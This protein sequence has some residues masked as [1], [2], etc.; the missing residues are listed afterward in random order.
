MPCI[1]QSLGVLRAAADLWSGAGNASASLERLQTVGRFLG[2]ARLLVSTE[3]GD[4]PLDV[5]CGPVSARARRPIPADVQPAA[6]SEGIYSHIVDPCFT[7]R[8]DGSGDG[9]SLSPSIVEVL[10]GSLSAGNRPAGGAEFVV[11][12]PAEG[13]E[14]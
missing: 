11:T 8:P 6:A 9:L 10:G 4:A 14:T 13:D 2:V 3:D 7:T 12:L 1:R 5:W